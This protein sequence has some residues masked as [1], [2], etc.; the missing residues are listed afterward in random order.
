[1][2]V[3]ILVDPS[4]YTPANLGDAAM[5]AVTLERLRARWPD[6]E[7]KVHGF[8]GKALQAIEARAELLD[9]YGAIAWSATG[10]H[11]LASLALLAKWRDPRAVGRFLKAVRAADLVLVAGAGHINDVFRRHAL[12]VL[13]MLELAIESGATTTLVGQGLG[14]LTDPALRRRAAMVLP[15]VDLIAL[16]EG[17]TGPRLLASLGVRAERVRVTGDDAIALAYRARR[18]F[19]GNSLGVNLRVAQYAKVGEVF[20]DVVGRVV[21]GRGVPLVALPIAVDEDFA[22]AQ[23]ILKKPLAEPPLT[24]AQLLNQ[25]PNCRVVVAGSYH[26][27]VLALA[28]G[29][30]AVTLANSPYYVDKFRGLAA[31]FGSACQ[32]LMMGD[33]DFERQ[34]RDAIDGAWSTAGSARDEL[35]EAARAQI[36]LG[37]RAFD[38]IAD[39]VVH[40]RFA[41]ISE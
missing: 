5:L 1:M 3:R 28:M 41:P 32:V 40:N 27:A 13:N 12:V 38:E 35:L 20:A 30:P 4:A 14:P 33:A 22:V 34:L 26:A 24:P 25:I 16:R 6:A 21:R 8:D 7:L 18:A 9:P 39:L 19:I 10:S 29:I 15:R 17:V 2:P 37:E 23:R 36:A 31:Q 11:V